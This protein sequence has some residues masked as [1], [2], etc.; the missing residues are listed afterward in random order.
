M[1][2]GQA[3][4][5]T[6]RLP[7]TELIA[8]LGGES[9]SPTEIVHAARSG[10]VDIDGDTAIVNDRRFLDIGEALIELGVPAATVLEEW[11]GL[12]TTMNEVAQRFETVFEEHLL[13]LLDGAS[14]D[15]VAAMLDR[16]AGLARDVTV[17][18]LD[19]ALRET[20]KRF[21]DSTIA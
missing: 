7:L 6:F 12:T 11:D 18:A 8:R 20:A 4:A 5:R 14:F 17:T 2:V 16:L 13:P 10:L 21:V 15:D 19:V 1:L 3:D 9:L